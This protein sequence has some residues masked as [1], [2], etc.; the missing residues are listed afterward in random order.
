MFWI[1]VSTWSCHFHCS[2]VSSQFGSQLHPVSQHSSLLYWWLWWM[3]LYMFVPGPP[4]TR[5]CSHSRLC[6]YRT[7]GC[8]MSSASHRW[9][10]R[11]Q[12]K[13]ALMTEWHFLSVPRWLKGMLET[14][15]DRWLDL[16][17]LVVGLSCHHCNDASSAWLLQIVGVLK[18]VRG[19]KTMSNTSQCSQ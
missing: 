15:I 16:L 13:R 4:S 14:K 6:G 19:R 7:H 1:L 2:P 12:R 8:N 10:W 5:G 3:W 9:L 11:Q 17:F 18:V